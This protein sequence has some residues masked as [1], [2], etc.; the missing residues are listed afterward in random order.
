MMLPLR[1]RL[2]VGNQSGNVPN[3]TAFRL[4]G[5]SYFDQFRHN[6]LFRS[7]NYLAD[8]YLNFD[9]VQVNGG[10]NLL[11][12]QE[13]EK[14]LDWV[15]G[16]NIKTDISTRI[17]KTSAYP[18]FNSIIP[19]ETFILG[20]VAIFKLD[21]NGNDVFIASEIALEKVRAIYGNHYSVVMGDLSQT[22]V[23]RVL[24]YNGYNV[25]YN[26]SNYST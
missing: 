5:A 25:F 24:D 2:Y 22:D 20:T 1:T 6:W 14:T 9:H 18:S 3:Q 7:N 4:S 10:A 13:N 26:F 11:S 23:L 15:V 21:E 8:N 19:V 12:Y 16:L 17:R